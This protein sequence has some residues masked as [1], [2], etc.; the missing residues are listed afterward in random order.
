MSKRSYPLDWQGEK[1][2]LLPDRAIFWAKQNTLYIA[3]THFGK[4]ATFRKAGIP[5][6]EHTTEED[7]QRLEQLLQSTQAER[8]VILGDFLHA[9]AGRT[10]PVR[11]LL[12]H[13]KEKFRSLAIILIR[14]NHDL[15]SGD[16]W[17]EL[18]IECLPDPTVEPNWDLR[19][20]PQ[21][22]KCRPFLAG[23]IHPGYRIQG[24]G[25]DTLRCP[26]WVVG[27]T[28][29]ILPAFGSFTG[30]KNVRLFEKE[31]AYLTNGEEIHAIPSK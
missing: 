28:R 2:E 1:I 10:E 26:C 5:V 20:L 27:P 24:K 6:S 21:E 9:R 8:L 13:W 31:K 11:T 23:H 30:L 17:P 14:G 16:P 29:I 18:G 3:D 19:H 22:S 15:Q 25:R 4:A 7:L 12:F